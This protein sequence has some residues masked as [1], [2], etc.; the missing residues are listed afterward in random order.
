ML[1]FT[2]GYGHTFN[3]SLL[4]NRAMNLLTVEVG[5]CCLLNPSPKNCSCEENVNIQ[6]SVLHLVMQPLISNLDEILKDKWEIPNLHTP[7]RYKIETKQLKDLLSD[8]FL[9]EYITLQDSLIKMKIVGHVEIGN[10]ISTE[11]VAIFRDNKLIIPKNKTVKP[12]KA[13]YR[14]GI[15]HVRTFYLLFIIHTLRFI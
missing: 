11:E 1:L 8:T 14:V 3:R 6:N 9:K 5:V 2:D 7:N 12:I 13:F 4:R 15:T 10:N